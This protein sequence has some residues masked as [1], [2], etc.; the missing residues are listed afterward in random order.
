MAEDKV[1]SL[2]KT[3]LRI[4][5]KEL[6]NL[7]NSYVDEIEERIKHFCNINRIPKALY[8]TWASMVIDALKIEQSHIDEIADSITGGQSVKIGDVSISPAKSDGITGTSKKVIEEIVLNYK[9]DLVRYRKM[10]W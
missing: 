7:I 1:L 4:S 3:R 8:F 6:D 2:V 9:T 10:R 5:N